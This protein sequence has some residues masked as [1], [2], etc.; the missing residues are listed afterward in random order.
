MGKSLRR[1]IRP[2]ASLHLTIEGREYCFHNPLDFEF[3]LA[4]RKF[5][6]VNKL[7]EWMQQPPA[8]LYKEVIN[9]KSVEGRFLEIVKACLANPAAAGTLLRELE[10]EQFSTDYHWREIITALREGGDERDA[11][12][13]I[14]LAKY[15]QYL[16]TRHELMQD[17][18]EFKTNLP[19]EE[20]P[21]THAAAPAVVDT[22]ETAIFEEAP[23]PAE[24]SR[25][26]NPFERLPHGQ[27]V[28]LRLEAGKPV[29]LLLARHHFKLFAGKTYRLVDEHGNF[30]LL[31]PGKNVLGR[32]RGSDVTLNND[33]RSI[34]RQHVIIEPIS[35]NVARLTDVSA[36][37]TFLPP[38]FLTIH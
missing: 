34:S 7:M 35:D 38:Q 18:F 31:H 5:L 24:P 4:G 22:G 8:M 10:P 23:P 32:Q 28:L 33:F 12:R 15:L 26:Y 13:R 25:L 36:H 27:A 37:G 17:L 21:K 29:D 3:A 9:L 16:S 20:S 11:Y 1:L 14:A 2:S 19:A 30:Y 6:P